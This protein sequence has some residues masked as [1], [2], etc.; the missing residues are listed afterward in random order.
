MDLCLLGHIAM[1]VALLV[2][3][4][5]E[6]LNQCLAAAEPSPA[7]ESSPAQEPS[8]SD[9][10]PWLEQITAPEVAAQK[11]QPRF[12]G[13]AQPVET[14]ESLEESKNPE[15]PTQL[16]PKESAELAQGLLRVVIEPN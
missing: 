14:F 3:I 15:P 6:G 5:Q 4:A 1:V 7:Q 11:P 9:A 8:P 10:M 12:P 13:F 16:S 2:G